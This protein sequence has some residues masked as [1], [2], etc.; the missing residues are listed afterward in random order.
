MKEST[1]RELAIRFV[2]DRHGRHHDVATLRLR[3]I[4]A[5][6]DGRRAFRCASCHE[7]VAAKAG[8]IRQPYFAHSPMDD[9][10]PVCPWRTDLAPCAFYGRNP[11]GDDGK[12][13]IDA[14]CEI[15]TILEM[16]GY[17]PTR[18][19][20]VRTPDGLRKP[21]IAVT[22][23]EQLVHFEVQVSPTDAWC[24]ARRTDRDFRH[25]AVTIWIVSAHAF[26]NALD[27]DAVP[28]WV[29]TLAAMGGGQIWL[30]DAECYRRSQQFGWLS[31][32]RSTIEDPSNLEPVDLPAQLPRVVP[33]RARLNH[34]GRIQLRYPI[35]AASIPRMPENL[36]HLRD[37]LAQELHTIADRLGQTYRYD[38]GLA[39]LNT[40]WPIFTILEG[41]RLARLREWFG[42]QSADTFATA[43]GRGLR[44]P[45]RQL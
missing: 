37:A 39:C 13:H 30:W 15:M 3:D 4:H 26:R 33:F 11:S 10:T 34:A 25:G 9:E 19:T 12:W 29:E 1:A 24:A 22:L 43:T 38:Y 27:H 31:P 17:Q 14:Q 23:D 7:P 6:P 20:A 42:R 28:A 32:L 8:F 35:T 18:N 40:P 21:D 5:Q 16:M 2:L 36:P 44:L 45:N 41:D